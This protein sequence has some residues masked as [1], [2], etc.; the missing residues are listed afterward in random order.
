MRLGLASSD[1]EE[2][3]ASPNRISVVPSTN[4]CGNHA[5]LRGKALKDGGDVQALFLKDLESALASLSLGG[6]SSIKVA[7][8]K[9]ESTVTEGANGP[10]SCTSS[11][12]VSL[13]HADP[14]TAKPVQSPS[15]SRDDLVS[16]LMTSLARRPAPPKPPPAELPSP[17]PRIKLNFKGSGPRPGNS[18]L[19][20]AGA[21]RQQPSKKS[22]AAAPKAAASKAMS[23][24][25]AAPAATQGVCDAGNSGGGGGGAAAHGQGSG[26]AGEEPKKKKAKPAASTCKVTHEHWRL[27]VRIPHTPAWR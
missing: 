19:G 16:R 4:A 1:G 13:S 20:G 5:F 21:S 12:S 3:E 2:S 14:S 17:P 6:R 15:L 24:K 25:A 8:P 18:G 22:N 26:G 10:V 9:L 23:S 11:S 27:L 7:A